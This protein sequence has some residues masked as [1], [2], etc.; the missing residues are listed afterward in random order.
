M[1][2]VVFTFIG[3]VSD[4]NHQTKIY[5]WRGKPSKETLF[6][7]SSQQDGNT[8]CVAQVE[9]EHTDSIAGG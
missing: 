6:G 9:K 7:T 3:F 4:A 5:W 1:E 8:T 2:G